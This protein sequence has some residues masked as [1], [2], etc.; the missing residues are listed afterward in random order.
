MSLFKKRDSS[1]LRHI[2]MALVPP[3]AFTAVPH[4]P[5]PTPTT[6]KKGRKNKIL[7]SPVIP[8]IMA[9]NVTA[10]AVAMGNQSMEELGLDYDIIMDDYDDETYAQVTQQRASTSYHDND[11]A[12][13]DDTVKVE[14][15]YAKPHKE[16][17]NKTRNKLSRKSKKLDPHPQYSSA[18]DGFVGD[19]P[20]TSLKFVGNP[21]ETHGN[22]PTNPHSIHG[23]SPA[24]ASPSTPGNSPTHPNELERLKL[25]ENETREIILGLMADNRRL[26]SGKS[27]KRNRNQP[28]TTTFPMKIF[29]A[30]ILNKF[31]ICFTTTVSHHIR[32][33]PTLTPLHP[34]GAG[35]IVMKQEVQTLVDENHVLKDGIRRLNNELASYQ[36]GEAPD[37]GTNE[38][39]WFTDVSHLNPLFVSYDKQLNDKDDVIIKYQSEL[40]ALMKQMKVV[41]A[42]NEVL[43]SATQQIRAEPIISQQ[44]WNNLKNQNS[45][46]MEEINNLMQ[47]L[48]LM[49]GKMQ[50]L[51]ETNV[52]EVA[53]LTNQLSAT[54]AAFQAADKESKIL[55]NEN[56]S[57]NEEIKKLKI[58]IG[59][60]ISMA[61]H[62]QEVALLTN[63][64]KCLKENLEKQTKNLN[65]KLRELQN[66]KSKLSLDFAETSAENIQLKEERRIFV[67]DQKKHWG[68]IEHLR[69]SLEESEHR[70]L[71]CQRHLSNVVRLAEQAA[72]E[73]A[74]MVGV[75]EREQMMSQ[76]VL[77]DSLKGKWELGK[78]E[79]TLK[80]CKVKMASQ[81]NEVGARLDEVEQSHLGHL[82]EY[83][84]K[85]KK[86][87]R[88]LE[89]K[90]RLLDDMRRSKIEMENEIENVWRAASKENYRMLNL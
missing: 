85:M 71:D 60:K 82:M 6:K 40:S 3:A 63:D 11:D 81:S 58:E 88:V 13:Y 46:L 76:Q 19:S 26:K 57:L 10:Q 77:H 62:D 18:Q 34:G 8:A 51:H 80:Q 59:E 56:K 5:P 37:V 67:E 31:W 27:P 74:M 75:A 84:R 79:Q 35:S 48:E 12:Y 21:P 44:K 32:G 24:G 65:S 66:T 55:K 72:M 64:I 86:L 23:N 45:L 1:P 53:S 14:D 38:D 52:E 70:E 43:H 25:K 69:R 28:T 90:Q 50:E 68:E 87:Q 2:G 33:I 73:R 22:F 29:Q 42:E 54:N 78:M 4:S 61:E 41:I 9:A 16:R 20:E 89:Q 83:E 7:R 30:K 15:L 36:G 39:P 47:Q 49:K 17:A